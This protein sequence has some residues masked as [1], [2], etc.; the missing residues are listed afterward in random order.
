MPLFTVPFC[1]LIHALL[2]LLLL[3]LLLDHM[4]TVWPSDVMHS[5]ISQC[6]CVGHTGHLYKNSW[7]YRGGT[8]E[9]VVDST[10]KSNMIYH[11]MH[12]RTFYFYM[13]LFPSISDSTTTQ[14]TVTF[15]LTI[16]I[17][18]HVS[19]FLNFFKYNT[20]FKA[21]TRCR[22][23]CTRD[24]DLEVFVGILGHVCCATNLHVLFNN[25]RLYPGR[26]WNVTIIKI[27]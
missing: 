7:I 14:P 16:S 1:I 18:W 20:L 24:K 23:H 9:T 6:L 10:P 2:L 15:P 8:Q 19:H 21:W 4:H 25:S 11:H 22:Y 26:N 27:K 12:P 3:L 5:M 13:C 17:Y